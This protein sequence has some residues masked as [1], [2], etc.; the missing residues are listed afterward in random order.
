MNFDELRAEHRASSIFEWEAVR[1]G[2]TIT[3]TGKDADGKP[4][5]ISGVTRILSDPDCAATCV[6][7]TAPSNTWLL[8]LDRREP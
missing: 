7:A 8:R 2:S 4:L 3:I 6:Y 5:K 1:L